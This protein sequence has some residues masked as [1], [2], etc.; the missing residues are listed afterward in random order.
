MSIARFSL[1]FSNFQNDRCIM[2]K[3][4]SRT[5]GFESLGDIEGLLEKSP[6]P[7]GCRYLK[8]NIVVLFD[9]WRLYGISIATGTSA[10][11]AVNKDRIN[12]R[13]IPIPKGTQLFV[14][15]P[16]KKKLA[17]K[18]LAPEKA[19]QIKIHKDRNPQKRVRLNAAG[20]DEFEGL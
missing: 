10:K 1:S 14:T 4:D 19:A 3:T 17:Q 18:E 20:I 16:A 13:W 8:S 2:V 11:A 6:S 7:K 12:P 15:E 5:I 9:K